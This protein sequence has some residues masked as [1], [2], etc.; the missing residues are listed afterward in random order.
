MSTTE[1]E[2]FDEG[3]DDEEEHVDPLGGVSTQSSAS[4]WFASAA[5]VAATTASGVIK[6]EPQVAAM[7]TTHHDGERRDAPMKMAPLPSQSS[8]AAPSIH[9]ASLAAAAANGG[10]LSSASRAEPATTVKNESPPRATIAS[11]AAQVPMPSATQRHPAP[12]A[13]V[14]KQQSSY[15]GGASYTQPDSSAIWLPLPPS[16]PPTHPSQASSATSDYNPPTAAS[17]PHYVSYSDGFSQAVPPLSNVRYSYGPP[18]FEP[19]STMAPASGSGGNGSSSMPHVYG[20]RPP[21]PVNYAPPRALSIQY[22]NLLASEAVTTAATM[23]ARAP[24]STCTSTPP[25][26]SA[27]SL[28]SSD[29]SSRMSVGACR[30]CRA[31]L[32]IPLVK[33]GLDCRCCG[34]AYPAAQFPT[35][36][37]QD[38]SHNR[39]CEAC[40]ATYAARDNMLRPSS[41]PF[42]T[43]LSASLSSSAATA[44]TT[45]APRFTPIPA[46]PR[47]PSS[48]A[49]QQPSAEATQSSTSAPAG[50]A[51]TPAVPLEKCAKCQHAVFKVQISTDPMENLK[52]VCCLK[53]LAKQSCFSKSQ[54]VDGKHRC[55]A[56]LGHAPLGPSGEPIVET[57]TNPSA[58]TQRNPPPAAKKKKQPFLRVETPVLGAERQVAKYHLA[59]RS[60]QRKREANDLRGATRVEYEK[61]LAKEEAE[62]KVLERQLRARHPALFDKQSGIQVRAPSIPND[63][64]D[65][66]PATKK[67]K[68]PS[69]SDLKGQKEKK[70]QQHSATLTAAANAVMRTATTSR[71]ASDVINLADELS[72]RTGSLKRTR[73]TMET[74]RAAAKADEESL[75]FAVTDDDASPTPKKRKAAIAASKSIA[76]EVAAKKQKTVNA[77]KSATTSA[78]AR[79]P[80][81]SSA[82]HD[83]TDPWLAAHDEIAQGLSQLLGGGLDDILSAGVSGGSGAKKKSSTTT[84]AKASAKTKALAKTARSQVKGEPANSVKNEDVSTTLKKEKKAHPDPSTYVPKTKLQAETPPQPAIVTRARRRTLQPVEVI[85]ITDSPPASPRAKTERV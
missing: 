67:R 38:R 6:P 33:S 74:L 49:V 61:Q 82:A 43:G 15:P 76:K 2:Y 32:R 47:I 18:R 85:D 50:A 46:P 77:S 44:T 4:A 8:A 69:K 58:T 17:Q 22:Q 29:S 28:P 70:A 31:S 75:T 60:L 56:C 11:H 78:T 3:R 51:P 27:T 24:V 20:Y 16:A 5:A 57:P 45:A 65:P 52:C 36:D 59:R 41:S 72:P 83:D 80:T 1:S 25:T 30:V 84:K 23:T 64:R 79:R 71:P 81:A 66:R 63:E 68:T 13:A 19:V 54:R 14:K 34:S 21:P 53:T 7:V 26:Y 39:R 55:K 12:I 37:D 10:A 62:L 73:V 40:F 35:Q 42:G 48:P 9:V